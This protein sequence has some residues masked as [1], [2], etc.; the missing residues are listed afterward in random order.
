LRQMSVTKYE[1][2]ICKGQEMSVS[3]GLPVLALW[4]R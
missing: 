1:L 3:G 2:R 4:R